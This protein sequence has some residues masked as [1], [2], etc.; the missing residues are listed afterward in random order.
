MVYKLDAENESERSP[1]I[2]MMACWVMSTLAQNNPF[3]QQAII[4]QG[5]LPIVLAVI[6]EST[7]QQVIQKA[8]AI[9]S[10]K[11]IIILYYTNYVTIN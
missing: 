11:L 7:N 6:T 3:A 1:K 9:I 8:L 5:I 10:G 4:D 2:R